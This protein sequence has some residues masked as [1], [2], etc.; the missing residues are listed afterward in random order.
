MKTMYNSI[1]LISKLSSVTVALLVRNRFGLSE[2]LAM[3]RFWSLAQGSSYYFKQV[4]PFEKIPLK[5]SLSFIPQIVRPYFLCSSLSC[6]QHAIERFAVGRW[7][8]A[9]PERYF[10]YRGLFIIIPCYVEVIARCLTPKC[11]FVR[12]S[13]V[14]TLMPGP[15]LSHCIYDAHPCLCHF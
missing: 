7:E 14:I 5:Y 6:V 2:E 1:L 12:C 4:L 11:S 3:K 15:F 9:S 10:E 8:N 13:L